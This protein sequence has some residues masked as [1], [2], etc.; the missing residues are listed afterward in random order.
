MKAWLFRWEGVVLQG[1]YYPKVRDR[2]YIWSEVSVS[3]KN[4]RYTIYTNNAESN[5]TLWSSGEHQT[6]LKYYNEKVSD[7]ILLF[8]PLVSD[9]LH[10]LY[11]DGSMLPLFIK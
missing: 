11:F 10:T 8:L 9:A 7:G 3:V 1:S 2:D 5:K 4:L 6:S